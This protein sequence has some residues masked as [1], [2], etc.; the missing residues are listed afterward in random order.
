[1]KKKS[2]DETHKTFCYVDSPIGRLGIAED[3]IGI[4]GLFFHQSAAFADGEEGA[5]SLLREAAAQ[6][7]DYFLRKR[8]VFDLPLSLHGT[9]FQVAVWGALQTIPYGETRSYKQIAEQI[10]KPNAYRAVGMANNR[11]PVSIVVPCHRVIGH[12]GALVGYGGGMPAKEYL[13]RLEA[14]HTVGA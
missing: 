10:G 11:N 4:S 2:A 8:Q 3:G 14:G 9:D 12:D 5:T 1:M 7:G 6:L 13:L